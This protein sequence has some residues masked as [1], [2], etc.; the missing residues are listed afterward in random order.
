[1]KAII[2]ALYFIT[3]SITQFDGSEFDQLKKISTLLCNFE[4]KKLV[5]KNQ[6][7]IKDYK[8]SK[9]DEMWSALFKKLI[10]MAM[11]GCVKDMEN[12]ANIE[13]LIADSK[14]SDLMNRSMP[15]ANKIKLDLLMK[16]EKFILSADEERYYEE[17][18]Q[19]EKEIPKGENDEDF[20]IENENETRDL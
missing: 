16:R 17:Y 13:S 18:M 14:G 7:A 8:I 4:V 9:G 20:D 11:E 12:P 3:I 19:S 5:M 2:L 6:E 15:F 1:M 10:G